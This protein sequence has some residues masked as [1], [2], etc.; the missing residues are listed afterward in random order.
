[1]SIN[2]INDAPRFDGQTALVTGATNGLGRASSFE[3][4][5]QGVETLIMGVRNVSQ[6]E[7]LKSELLALAPQVPVHVVQLQLDDFSSVVAFSNHVTSLTSRL[8][9]DVLNAGVGGYDSKLSKSG[10]ENIMQVNAYS[11]TL[12]VLELLPLLE[13]IAKERSRPSRLTWVGS[14]VQMDH[15]LTKK[16]LAP[17]VSVMNQLDDVNR[18]VKTRYQDSKLMTTFVVERLVSDVN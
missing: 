5:K 11:N 4:V 10:H 2:H 9:I 8:D 12:L 14:F 15:G 16:P 18:L 7:T 1:M 6:G 17:G 3:L 13:Q